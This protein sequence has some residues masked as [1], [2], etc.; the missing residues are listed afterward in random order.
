MHLRE[1]ICSFTR[2][3]RWRA[4]AFGCVSH[5]LRLL[6]RVRS[7]WRGLRGSKWRVGTVVGH[8]RQPGEE[9]YRCMHVLHIAL[10]L[11]SSPDV[12]LICPSCLI[13]QREPLWPV[14]GL[15]I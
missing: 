6:R 5:P 1:G 8:K 13:A 7:R 4:Q 11:T 10:C 2:K 15:I 9:R 3:P 12:S 14:T